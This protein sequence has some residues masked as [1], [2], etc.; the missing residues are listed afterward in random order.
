VS[1]RSWPNICARRESKSNVP[2]RGFQERPKV[3][4]IGLLQLNSTVG[5]FSANQKELPAGYEKI[6]AFGADFIIAPEFLFWGFHR[7][8]LF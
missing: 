4:L 2:Q 6:V 3:I 8:N 1:N 7:A 5:D